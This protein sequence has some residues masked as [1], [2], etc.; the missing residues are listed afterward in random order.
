MGRTHRHDKP[1]DTIW[2]IDD[3]LWQ[4]IEPILLEDA[5][6]KPKAHGGRPR[7]DWRLAINGAIFRL[8]SGCQWNKLPQ[9]FG[10]DS[11]VHRWFQRWCRNG[12][13]EQIWAVLLEECDELGAVHWRWQAADGR[14]G[15]DLGFGSAFDRLVSS[16]RGPC[17][18]RAD[19]TVCLSVLFSRGR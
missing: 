11:S 1:L 17:S 5:P 16:A 14:I 10:D 4:R 19:E 8:R 6:A 15:T 3:E 7:I 2:E 9:C 18:R 13:F 12:V